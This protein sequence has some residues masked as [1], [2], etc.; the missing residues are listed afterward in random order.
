MSLHDETAQN[1]ATVS[2][3]LLDFFLSKVAALDNELGNWD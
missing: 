3:V 2:S 1:I